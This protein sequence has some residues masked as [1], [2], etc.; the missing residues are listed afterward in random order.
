MYMK[1]NW[2]Y[3]AY[4]NFK[5]QMGKNISSNQL[6]TGWDENINE[7]SRLPSNYNLQN[8]K[9]TLHMWD[10]CGIVNTPYSATNSAILLHQHK[11]HYF[12]ELIIQINESMK[13]KAIRN[14][15]K[16]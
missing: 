6:R 9:K 10:L 5:I 7:L 12:G 11:A 8:L 13:P 16:Q 2:V 4:L 15:N 14:L 3:S 1:E